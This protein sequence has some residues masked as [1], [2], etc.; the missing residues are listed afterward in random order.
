MEADGKI[1]LDYSLEKAAEMGFGAVCFEG[2]EAD[3]F[4]CKELKPGYLE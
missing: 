3:F 2:M 1:L 4:L